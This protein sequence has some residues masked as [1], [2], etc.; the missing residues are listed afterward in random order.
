M[1]RDEGPDEPEH[2]QLARFFA[3][4][5]RIP[6]LG[7]DIRPHLLEGE[8]RRM[9]ELPPPDSA[10]GRIRV[11]TVP[12]R[13]YE[14]R[15][16][17]AAMPGLPYVALGVFVRAGRAAGVRDDY[18]SGRAACAVFGAL[19]VL[20]AGLAAL[21]LRPD[22]PEIHLLAPAAVAFLPQF[23]FLGAY[24]NPDA[25]TATV[26]AAAAWRFAT[27]ASRG[28]PLRDA[29]VFGV[30]CGAGLLCKLNAYPVIAV[31][32]VAMAATLR[33]PARSRIVRAAAAA[34]AAL[35]VAAP[36]FV[37]NLREYGELLGSRAGAA[38]ASAPLAMLPEE[39]R[40]GLRTYDGAFSGA[41]QGQSYLS[42]LTGP[43]M[44][45]TLKSSVGFFG[46]LSKPMRPWMYGA[47][48]AIG[49]AALAGLLVALVRARSG[50]RRIDGGALL[51]A[52]A[53]AVALVLAAA[54]RQSLRYDLQ[55]QGRYLFPCL[56]G[57]A[58][59]FALAITEFGRSPRARLA[60][61]I[62]V[63]GVLAAL[64]AVA[65]RFVLIA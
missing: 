1:P 48:A 45:D 63:S 32:A 50:H 57:T 17:Y 16:H 9:I 13:H 8:T 7:S 11:E 25:L 62:G 26:C 28:W 20:A 22:R 4:H 24:V 44:T 14:L 33:G 3:D 36:W 10:T 41:A 49:A 37:H 59:L 53:V 58:V 29:L 31:L 51:V 61:A 35:V 52:T 30:V 6:V 2:A 12:G 5:G 56:G 38:Y 55:P 42:L 47:Y 64:S 60:I 39:L 21:R 27:G 65:F 34:G 40:R 18:A 23:V 43:W 54:L 15:G 19:A 46:W